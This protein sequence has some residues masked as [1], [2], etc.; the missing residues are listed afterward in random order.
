MKYE[1]KG[2]YNPVVEFSL[3]P[4]ESIIGDGNSLGWMEPQ[5]QIR[6]TGNKLE[7]IMN[8][9]SASRFCRNEYTA[10]N[11]PALVA[12]APGVAGM[13]QVVEI[14]P[15]KEIICPA[16]AFLASTSG[17]TA[18]AFL[19]KRFGSGYFGGEG[20]VLEK[21]SGKGMAFLMMEGSVVERELNEDEELITDIGYL[22]AM[23]TSCKFEL[24]R[25]IRKAAKS[26]AKENA[27][28]ARIKG[29]GRIALQTMPGCRL[30]RTIRPFLINMD[31]F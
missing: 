20:I 30:A 9:F 21:I 3:E 17:V 14:S 18:S 5:V 10:K 11:K 15:E 19:R 7:K 13:I 8:P 29:P 23:D 24:S 31:R 26:P 25:S 1:I 2:D 12:F 28:Y 22:A 27:Y 16:N 6:S 4:E